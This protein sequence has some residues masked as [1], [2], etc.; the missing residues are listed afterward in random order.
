MGRALISGIDTLDVGLSV[1]EYK[2]SSVEL[3]ALLHAKE[4]AQQAGDC[5]DKADNL[6]R[7]HGFEFEVL[8][9][10]TPRH[11]FILKNDDLTVKI[12]PSAN[13]GEKYPEIM[14]HFSSACL[15]REGVE[16]AWKQVSEWINNWACV[17]ENKVSRVDLC[18]DVESPLPKLSHDFREVVSRADKRKQYLSGDFS[19]ERHISGLRE[20]G[21]SFGSNPMIC[22]IYDKTLE[23]EKKSHKEWFY[24]LWRE[25]GWQSG[26]VTRTEFQI[27]RKALKVRGINTV[28]QLIERQADLWQ[29]LTEQW[30]TL[31]VPKSSDSN[32]S[33]W[34]TKPFWKLVQGGA[35]LFGSFRQCI[36]R[37]AQVLP[38]IDT[39]EKQALGVMASIGAAY[40]S[41]K[42]FKDC[43][44]Y[45][46]PEFLVNR[47]TNWLYDRKFEDKVQKRTVKFASL[48]VGN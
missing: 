3:S 47:M 37:V 22:R 48:A 24:D 45:G 29:Y 23:I 33:R 39:L 12:C 6:I 44:Y 46:K 43:D 13:S 32:R 25:A 31:V 10:G 11:E 26:L 2:L 7:L 14:V 17:S 19:I 36:K 42:E 27:R 15:W 34:N 40:R 1:G 20:S 18:C 41:V 4:E 5:R 38:R 9:G 28:E 30:I 21:F 16:G 8:P 35:S